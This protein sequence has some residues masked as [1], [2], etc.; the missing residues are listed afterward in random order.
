MSDSRKFDVREWL[1]SLVLVP[2]FFALLIAAE[3]VL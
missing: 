3:A 2:I 1:V